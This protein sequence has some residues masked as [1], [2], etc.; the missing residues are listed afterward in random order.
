MATIVVNKRSGLAD[1]LAGAGNIAKKFV[2]RKENEKQYAQQILMKALTGELDPRMLATEEGAA[3]LRQLRIADNPNVAA[4]VDQGVKDLGP[5]AREYP[6][7]TLGIPLP[8]G[9]AGGLAQVPVPVPGPPEALPVKSKDVRNVIAREEAQRGLAVKK[10][11]LDLEAG[12]EIYV[13]LQ[14]QAI[15]S[16][17]YTPEVEAAIQKAMETAMPGFKKTLSINEKGQKSLKIEQEDPTARA[18]RLRTNIL[19][20]QSYSDGVVS[21]VKHRTTA[22]G[23]LGRILRGEVEAINEWAASMNGSDPAMAAIA[24]AVSDSSKKKNYTLKSK[25]AAKLYLT[26]MN[27]SIDAVNRQNLAV[28]QIAG[29][30]TDRLKAELVPHIEFEDIAGMTEA[31]WDKTPTDPPPAD[32]AAADARAAAEAAKAAAAGARPAPVQ[33]QAKADQSADK[34]KVAYDAVVAKVKEKLA[35]PGM[36]ADKVMTALFAPNMKQAFQRQYGVN[37]KELESLEKMVRAAAKAMMKK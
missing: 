15:E 16:G 23:A 6:T 25:D 28:G 14:K 5:M 24:A 9:V 13:A 8:G 2:Q 11:G 22:I 34:I 17:L 33:P 18:G 27:Q 20:E 26:A 35:T 3:I 32:T 19:N 37:A 21:G 4:L 10:A 12:K 31:E 29:I 30:P 1:L 7:Q 36:T